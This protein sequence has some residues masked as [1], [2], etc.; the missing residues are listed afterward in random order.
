[1]RL[2]LELPGLTSHFAVFNAGCSVLGDPLVKGVAYDMTSLNGSQR[3][4][5]RGCAH[6]L[7]AVVWIGKQGLTDRV[8]ASVNEALE[9]REL[10][11]V[12]FVDF[13]KEKEELSRILS[14]KTAATLVG[15]IG[16]I[17]ILYRQ[18][19]NQEKRKISLPEQPRGKI[20]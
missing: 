1:M 9:A 8:I 19:V 18:N 5:L 15:M 2:F 12:K 11:K 7:E 6:A 16:N 10:I 3:K 13:K 14:E 17:A 4:Y 20:S